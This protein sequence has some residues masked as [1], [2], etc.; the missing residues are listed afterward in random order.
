VR[1]I[2]LALAAAAVGLGGAGAATLALEH[3]LATLTPGGIEIA[4]LHYNPFSGRLALAGVRARDTGGREVFRADHVVARASPLPLLGGS[5]TLTRVRVAGP[6]LTLA[7]PAALV[8]DLPLRIE[9]VAV[10]G[11]SV[12]IEQAGARGTPLRAHGLQLRLGRLA[13]ARAGRP[14]VA[15]AAEMVTYGTLVRVTGQPGAGG[16][17]L[18]VRARDVDVAALAR[19]LPGRALAG[20]LAGR[21]EIDAVL[22]LADG[23][24]LAA[25]HARVAGLVVALPVRG[26]PRLRA[27]TVLVATDGFDPVSGAG[28]LTRVVVGAPSL[29]LPVATAASTLAAFLEWLRGPADLLVRRVAVTDGTLALTGAGG[30]R[31][32]RVQVAARA[33]ERPGAG[34]WAVNAR[35]TLDSGAQ[36][37]LDGRLARDLRALDAA[38]RVRRAG[39]APWRALAG[40][41]TR[42]DS[43]VSFEGRLRVAARE[44]AVTLTGHASLAG[45]EA[46]GPDA[47]VGVDRSM[48]TAD[49]GTTIRELLSALEDAAHTASAAR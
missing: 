2:L 38:A 17:A 37:A 6:R 14:D 19:D 25:G 33:G 1:T 13:V 48:G 15:F 20:L 11:G 8:P 9:D 24:V 23:Q 7:S 10:S 3:R 21:G 43:R 28:R 42:W 36:V 39:R 34:G 45:P 46:G 18:H 40:E 41:A 35:A 4:A 49:L 16:Y 22:Q 44:G 27:A 30:V 12:V 47:I 5:L 31:L 29:A 26:R 32:E